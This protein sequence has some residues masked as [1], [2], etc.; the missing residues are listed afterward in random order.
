MPVK[1]EGPPPCS[2]CPYNNECDYPEDPCQIL[3]EE[4]EDGTRN[5]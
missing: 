3:Q 2:T 4:E 1:F 5:A